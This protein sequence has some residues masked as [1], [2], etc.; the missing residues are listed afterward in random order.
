MRVFDGGWIL[1][2][3]ERCAGLVMDVFFARKA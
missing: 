2:E 3:V 1:R